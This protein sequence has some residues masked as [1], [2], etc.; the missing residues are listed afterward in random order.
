MVLYCCVVILLNHNT[1]QGQ[2][3]VIVCHLM[4]LF[5]QWMDI[6]VG[7]GLGLP[8]HRP[9]ERGSRKG[10]ECAPLHSTGDSTVR[11]TN[12]RGISVA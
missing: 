7:G 9:V 2:N 1:M 10:V 8:V 5:L 3:I 6:G 11:G 12:S 4:P